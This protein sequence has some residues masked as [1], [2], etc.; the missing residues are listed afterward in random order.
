MNYSIKKTHYNVW[1]AETQIMLTDSLELSIV[2]MKRSSGSL[3]TT[4]TCGH[5]KNGFIEH[6]MY[7]DFNTNL[8]RSNPK[9]ITK[10]VVEEQ[11]LKVYLPDVRE[12]ALAYYNLEVA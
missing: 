7:Q 5:F 11:H 4:A 8:E 6:Q 2:T 9:R 1:R 3:L 12:W 10:N